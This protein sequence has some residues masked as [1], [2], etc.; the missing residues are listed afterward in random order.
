MTAKGAGPVTGRMDG[1]RAFVTGGGSG[2]GKATA[3]RLAAEGAAVAVADIR[4]ESAVAVAAEIDAAGGQAIAVSTDVGSEA[5]VQDAVT[6]AANAFGG[7]DTVFA[8]AGTA[9]SGWLHEL[10]LDDWETVLRINLTGTFLTAKH[11]IPHL[12]DNGSGAIVTTGSIE[13]QVIALGGS[14]AS[15]AASKGGV[16]QLTRQI[17]V[18][19]GPQE[20]RANC[21]CP[22]VVRTRLAHHVREDAGSHTSPVPEGGQLPRQH[23]EAPIQRVGQPDEQAAVAV[24]LL[25]DD[26]SFMTASAV[27]VDG[28]YTAI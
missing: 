5:S 12:L 24:F 18:D 8:N 25:S 1:R 27:T 2:I 21:L 22:G 17:A 20:I 14:A 28:G 26:A 3:L 10:T 19:Y 4:A 6:E 15:Y 9:G 13:S 16:L 23:I 7:L 11:T